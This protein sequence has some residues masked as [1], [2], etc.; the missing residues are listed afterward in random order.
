MDDHCIDLFCCRMDGLLYLYYGGEGAGSMLHT[1]V[2]SGF[3]GQQGPHDL[4]HRIV[5]IDNFGGLVPPPSKWLW[6]PFGCVGTIWLDLLPS[7]HGL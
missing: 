1:H 6:T 5:T 7:M 4:K 3:L 2:Q